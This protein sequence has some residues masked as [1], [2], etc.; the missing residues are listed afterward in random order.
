MGRDSIHCGFFIVRR[1]SL[2]LFCLALAADRAYVTYSHIDVS[3][4][5]GR[6]WW[7]WEGLTHPENRVR[8]GEVPGGLIE[9]YVLRVVLIENAGPVPKSFTRWIRT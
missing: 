9:N 3:P 1:E 5:A 8:T 4:N 2:L 6:I 7:S